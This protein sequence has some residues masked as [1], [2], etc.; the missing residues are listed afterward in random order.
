MSS[1]ATSLIHV[2]K[3]FEPVRSTLLGM[4]RPT[5]IYALAAA[6]AIT[7]TVKEIDKYMEAWR[8]MFYTNEWMDSIFRAWDCSSVTMFG[9]DLRGIEDMSEAMRKGIRE[10]SHYSVNLWR[11]TTVVVSVLRMRKDYSIP[12]HKRESRAASI[13]ASYMDCTVTISDGGYRFKDVSKISNGVHFVLVDEELG[14]V[15]LCSRIVSDIIAFE[16]VSVCQ[17]GC[18]F[19]EQRIVLP[20]TWYI[21]MEGEDHQLMYTDASPKQNVLEQDGFVISVSPQTSNHIRMYLDTCDATF[22][23]YIP[24]GSSRIDGGSLA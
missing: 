16:G 8:Q 12:A 21:F 18:I 23:L 24:L 20:S 14:S 19:M 5:D 11:Q 4:L 15:P 9:K 10:H 6:N 7:I 1:P 2:L 13:L 22:F 3:T 17:E